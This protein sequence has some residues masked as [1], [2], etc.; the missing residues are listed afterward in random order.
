MRDAAIEQNKPTRIWVNRLDEIGAL[1]VEEQR[2]ASPF[3]TPSQMRVIKARVVA[4]GIGIGMQP[5]LGSIG[6][7]IGVASSEPVVFHKAVAQDIPYLADN[8]IR[9]IGKVP[10]QVS[11]PFVVRMRIGAVVPLQLVQEPKTF[12]PQY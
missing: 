2:F 8:A 10:I 4:F 7:A 5:T 11:I 1:V 3:G 6:V 12:L 9:R